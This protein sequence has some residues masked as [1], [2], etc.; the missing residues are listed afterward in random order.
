M[1]PRG[2]VLVLE[3]PRG[4]RAVALALALNTK[5]LITSLDIGTLSSA[6][7]DVKMAKQVHRFFRQSKSQDTFFQHPTSTMNW[8]WNI[9]N[10]H[11]RSL[12]VIGEKHF[13]GR[14]NRE[15]RGVKWPPKNNL[16]G[17]QTWYFDPQ[18][19]FGK[20]YFLVHTHTLLL[21]LH[22]NSIIFWN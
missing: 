16:P 11:V 22:H 19:F 14:G 2:L 4:Q 15:L 9:R 12:F 21:R 13:Q 17:C 18:I 7:S 6:C 20:K 10:I 5:S 3:A 1:C 8:Q